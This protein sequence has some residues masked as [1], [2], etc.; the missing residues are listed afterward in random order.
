MVP[1]DRLPLGAVCGVLD[2]WPHGDF[3]LAPAAQNDPGLD[4]SEHRC[5]SLNQIPSD[6]PFVLRKFIAAL[7]PATLCVIDTKQS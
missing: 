2:H 4:N 7:F 1:P 5:A 3:D 6:H